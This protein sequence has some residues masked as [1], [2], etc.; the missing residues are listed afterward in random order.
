M[1]NNT[2]FM[3]SSD[4]GNNGLRMLRRISE[5]KNGGSNVGQQKSF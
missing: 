3:V 4:G 2:D 5:P 1:N